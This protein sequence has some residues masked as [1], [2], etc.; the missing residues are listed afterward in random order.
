MDFGK[1][2]DLS[3]FSRQSVL[4]INGNNQSCKKI[5]KR[6]DEEL[7]KIIPQGIFFQKSFGELTEQEYYNFMKKVGDLCPEISNEMIINLMQKNR[8]FYA[9]IYYFIHLARKNL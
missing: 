7:N 4:S 2:K 9:A 5:V 8:Y 6:I 1:E 3:S